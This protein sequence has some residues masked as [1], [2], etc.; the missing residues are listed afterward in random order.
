MNDS[1]SDTETRR[2]QA[3]HSYHILDTPR[4]QAFDD[5]THLVAL[6]CDVPIAL[7]SLVD[8]NRQWFKS[9]VGLGIQETGRDV[10]ICAHAIL[11]PGLF[12]VKDT[13]L[14]KRFANNPLVTRDP[15]LRF[16]AGARLETADG[17]P[18][19]T[20]CVLDHEPRELTAF[21]QEALTILARQVMHLLDLYR[22]N[23]TQ[24]NMLEELKK[25]KEQLVILASTDSLTGLMNRRAFNDRLA[26]EHAL[27]HRNHA[28]SSLLM[29]DIDRF[30]KLNDVHGHYVGDQALRI[31][32][33][34][35]KKIFR[36]MDVICRWGGEEFLVLLP[37]T[38]LDQ[39]LVVAERL[40]TSLR[41]API[42]A[43]EGELFITISIGALEMLEGD[44][45][46]KTLRDL[47]DLLYEAKDSGRD[48]IVARAEG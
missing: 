6:L 3:L 40:R 28:Q 20:F 11:Q 42:P 18:L 10:S 24:K 30:K 45:L 37:D 16:Y 44:S 25:A 34:L 39:A 13:L 7:I 14:D 17:D 48:R 4:D 12:I 21:Q 32:A 36:A 46:F 19:G 41:E 27:V 2:L 33:G 23:K 26:Q 22:V 35:C 43:E 29:I 9:E 5:L 1:P 38:P 8:E 31:F 47:D 15:H